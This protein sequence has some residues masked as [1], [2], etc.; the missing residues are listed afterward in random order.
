MGA[1]SLLSNGSAWKG[2]RKD[3]TVVMKNGQREH[4]ATSGSAPP[5][6]SGPGVLGWKMDS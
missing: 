1:A 5:R 4:R 2:W 6:G 3:E